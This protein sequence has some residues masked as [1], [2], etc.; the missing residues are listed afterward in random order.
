VRADKLSISLGAEDVRW[1]TRR[2]K[3]LGTSVSS[4]IA[5]AVADSRRAEARDRLLSLLG[6]ADVRDADVVAARVEAFGE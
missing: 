1:L 2:A 5:A 3:R 4:V 6:D